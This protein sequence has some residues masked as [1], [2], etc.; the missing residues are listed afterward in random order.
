MGKEALDQREVLERIGMA[1]QDIREDNI[2]SLKK[3]IETSDF[4]VEGILGIGLKG[5][6][7]PYLRQII[8]TIN[9]CGKK[10]VSCDIPSGL[11]PQTGMPLGAAIKADYTVTFLDPKEG[12]F[13]NQ[14]PKFCGKIFT[15]DIGVSREILEKL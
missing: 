12:F 15:V 6:V 1:I 10:V 13:L 11:C 2:S 5:E 4:I 9:S 8:D 7:S 14:A 3:M